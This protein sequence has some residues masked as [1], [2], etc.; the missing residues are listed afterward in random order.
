MPKP[1]VLNDEVKVNSYGF[2]VLNAG[3]NLER[4]NQNP[5]MLD[6]HWESNHYVLGR[7]ENLRVEGT[8]M[9]ADPVFDMEDESASKVAGKVERDFI[10]GCSLG[11]IYNR[12][13]MKL[14]LDGVYVLEE[15]ELIEVSIVAVPSNANA[16]RLYNQSGELLDSEVVKLSLSELTNNSLNPKKE[17]TMKKIALSMLALTALGYTE[18]PN[19]TD[20][21]VA[22]LSASI[23]KMKQDLDKAKADLQKYADKEKEAVELAAKKLVADAIEAGKFTAE[24]KGEF[25]KMALENLAL[26]TKVIGGMPVKASLAGQVDNPAATGE[27]KTLEDFQ[28]LSLDKQLAFK[29]QNPEGYKALF[30]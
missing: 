17:D 13:K 15:C 23:E 24:L 11:L 30:V 5:V 26:A 6:Q 25:E 8:L 19:D 28:K 12:D 29:S 3:I 7:W 2:R 18:Q 4:F 21:D 1:F 9:I 27:V 10:K 16:I 22:K 20:T 14:G